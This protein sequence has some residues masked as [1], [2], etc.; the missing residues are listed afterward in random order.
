MPTP[1]FENLPF[2]TDPYNS[3]V[4]I[5]PGKYQMV[6]FKPG[7]PLQASELNEIQDQIYVQQ[8]LTTMMW[9]NWCTNKAASVTNSLGPGW[10]GA[11]PIEPS[12]IGLS[13][14]V[15]TINKGWYL[16]K[17]GISN[18]YFWLY[19]NLTPLNFNLNNVINNHYIGFTIT[20]QGI[21]ANGQPAL[22]GEFV[23]CQDDPGLRDRNTFCGA[24]RYKI[25]ITSIGTS[26][27]GLSS[28][29]I[30]IIQ[31]SNDR[32]IFLNNIPVGEI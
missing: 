26:E 6:A 9:S 24:D 25:Q 19:N 17:M 20:T 30:P 28:S 18:L 11:T 1:N 2:V 21:D 32:F 31:K 10:S 29:F 14:T 23:T 12:L 16:C 22:S 3:R 5:D 8:A 4:G 13:G 7:Y 15:L 27:T